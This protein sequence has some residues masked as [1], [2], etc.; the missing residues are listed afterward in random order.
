MYQRKDKFFNKAKKEGYLARS[1]YKLLE[2]NDKY[3]VIKSTDRVLDLGSSPGSWV[4]VLLK[5][6]IKKITAVDIN[7]IKIK[8]E[9]IEFIKVDIRDVNL[10]GKYDV[11]LSDL[12]PKT[13]G[14][15]NIDIEG[16]LDLTEMAFEIAKKYLKNDGNFIAKVFMGKGFDSLLKEIKTDFKQ[17]KTY[18]PKAVRKSSKEVYIIGVNYEKMS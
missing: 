12:A 10:K 3:K 13:S 18:K 5:L 4:Q 6:K 1:A 15:K 11:V 9:N 7:N 16:S 8:H 2:I 17:C 14:V